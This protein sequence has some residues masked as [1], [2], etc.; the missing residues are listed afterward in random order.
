MGDQA[1]YLFD[2]GLTAGYRALIEFPGMGHVPNHQLRSNLIKTNGSDQ[3]ISDFN[4][5]LKVGQIENAA[6]YR[7]LIREV[8]QQNE[9]VKDQAIKDAVKKRR[10]ELIIAFVKSTTLVDF[11]QDEQGRDA[12]NA[13][14]GCVRTEDKREFLKCI[15]SLTEGER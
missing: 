13:L 14:G 11:I 10:W 8:E 6:A 9:A 3:A 2:N 5:S 15:K 4:K 12:I 7:A 1:E